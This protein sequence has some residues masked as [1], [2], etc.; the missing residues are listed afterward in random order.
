LVRAQA[1]AG[2]FLVLG[3]GIFA[4]AIVQAGLLEPLLRPTST[5]RILLP[6]AGLAGLERGSQVQLFGT[7]IGEVTDVVVRP[8]EPFYAEAR[9]ES[10]KRAFIRADSRV[11]VR[12]QF[13][14]A[15]AA[16]LDIGRGRGDELD[17]DF[18]VLEAQA[19]RAPTEGVGELIE[20]ARERILPLVDEATRAIALAGDLLAALEAPEEDFRQMLARANAVSASI[21]AGEGTFG[22]VL[23]DDTLVRALETTVI[24]L[25]AQIQAL[26]PV[27]ANADVLMD[28][29][30]D[31]TD[32]V[33]AGTAD[34]GPLLATVDSTL[35]SA[36]ALAL[37]LARAMPDFADTAAGA[38]RAAAELPEV[39]RR[40]SQTLA[41][42]EDLLDA[43]RRSWLLGGGAPTPAPSPLDVRP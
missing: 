33:A 13:G 34:L 19:E 27:I 38:G 42:L 23:N 2:L 32:N 4:F 5:L 37:E 21:A 30:I 40:T 31:V 36:D 24:L 11:F 39:L 18:A 10:D 3:L 14:I 35:K 41:Q 9:I 15:G 43:L 26:E 8:D 6:E 25:N 22:R 28:N 20:E 12:R 1:G 17:W 16:F 29:V 7:A